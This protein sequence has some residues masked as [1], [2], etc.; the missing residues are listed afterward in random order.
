[1]TTSRAIVGIAWLVVGGRDGSKSSK[2][3][4][5]IPDD[6]TPKEFYVD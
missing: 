5:L 4:A 1:M 3:A 2:I 6:K